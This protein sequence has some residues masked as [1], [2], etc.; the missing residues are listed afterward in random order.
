MDRDDDK[1]DLGDSNYDEFSG[2]SGPVATV[3]EN[4]S[5]SEGFCTDHLNKKNLHVVTSDVLG[6]HLENGH[7]LE[8]SVSSLQTNSH[9]CSPQLLKVPKPCF[10][11]DF[12]REVRVQQLFFKS[13]MRDSNGVCMPNA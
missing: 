7:T 8:K 11:L 6:N 12:G 2:Y 13:N 9:N 4:D 5:V 3:A 1:A 10:C